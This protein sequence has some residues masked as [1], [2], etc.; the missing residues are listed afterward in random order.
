[1]LV[2]TYQ[3]L[4]NIIEQDHRAIKRRP[5]PLLAGDLKRNSLHATRLPHSCTSASRVKK[6]SIVLIE[7]LLCY[8]DQLRNSHGEYTTLPFL[9]LPVTSLEV[10][11]RSHR[12]RYQ[13]TH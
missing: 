13:V 10:R 1:M 6:P 11:W 2:R 8:S 7:R 5:F 3:Y 9:P 4:N 12:N